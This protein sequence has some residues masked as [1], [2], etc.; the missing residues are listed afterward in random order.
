MGE[1]GRIE[2]GVGHFDA[3]AISVLIV[4]AA[5]LEARFGPRFGNWL[6]DDPMTAERFAAAVAGN[7]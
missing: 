5:K 4:F 3:G 1:V 7:E 2:F 6:D